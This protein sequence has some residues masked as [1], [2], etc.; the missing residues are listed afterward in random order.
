MIYIY[1]FNIL[2]LSDIHKLEPIHARQNL[3]P[4]LQI[5]SFFQTKKPKK[6]LSYFSQK[7]MMCNT[8]NGL[9]CNLWTMQA[10]WSACTHCQ[11]TNQSVDIVVYVHKQI[12][13]RLDC[14]DV[15]ADLDLCKLHKGPFCAVPIICCLTETLLTS[16]YNIC[17]KI[18]T[19]YTVLSGPMLKRM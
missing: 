5:W 15:H 1:F 14:T 7:H 16:T 18:F 6:Y 12:M 19:W 11:L 8:Q 13:L 3:K 17:F 9:L 4:F 10:P 2:A